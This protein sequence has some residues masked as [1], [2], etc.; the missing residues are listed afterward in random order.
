ML[1]RTRPETLQEHAVLQANPYAPLAAIPTHRGVFYVPWTLECVQA[2]LREEAIDA[3]DLER[4]HRLFRPFLR[5]LF[6]LAA[7]ETLSQDH[8]HRIRDL[9]EALRP[10]P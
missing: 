7:Q 1:D 5:R 6:M 10:S 2:L 4:R 3:R 8:C 9:A